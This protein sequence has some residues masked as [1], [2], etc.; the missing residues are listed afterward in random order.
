[1]RRSFHALLIAFAL[2]ALWAPARAGAALNLPIVGFGEQRSDVFSDPHWQA[3]GLKHMRLVVGWDFLAY[4]WQRQQADAWLQAAHAAGATPL[5]AFTRSRNAARKH[6]LPSRELYRYYFKRFRKRYPWVTTFI[7]WNEENHCSQPLCHKPEVAAGYFDTLKSSCPSCTIVAADVL[8]TSD[9]ASWLRR[10]RAAA[11]HPPRIWGLHNYLDANYFRTTGTD[12]MLRTVRGDVWFTETGG[13]VHRANGSPI[14]F[15]ENRAHAA[16]ATRFVL[17]VLAQRSHRIKRVYLYHFSNQ[18]P[19]ATWDSG[20]LDPHG[21]PR[22]AF[23]V[24]QQWVTRSERARR[25]GS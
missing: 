2:T 20:V 7:T 6:S 13:L 14:H 19:G 15:V 17:D 24:V 25:S 21:K 10:F 5:I 22:P 16:Q 4:R 11:H 12:T 3:L 18:G 8:D 23:K 1:M 9:M